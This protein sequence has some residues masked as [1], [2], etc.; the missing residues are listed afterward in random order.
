MLLL[1]I[2]IDTHH[3]G[4]CSIQPSL[5]EMIGVTHLRWV[6]WV[7]LDNVNFLTDLIFSNIQGNGVIDL[8]R[9][10]MGAGGLPLE[11]QPPGSLVAYFVHNMGTL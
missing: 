4:T 6:G 5:Y 9:Y 8:F 11:S 1:C 2:D 7:V 10:A 3:T